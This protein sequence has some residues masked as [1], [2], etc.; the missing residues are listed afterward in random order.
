MNKE[1]IELG[2]EMLIS[3]TIIRDS[4]IEPYFI[5]KDATCYTV[6]ELTKANNDDTKPKRGRK[7]VVTEENKNKVYLKSHGYYTQF[8]NCLHKISE[9]KVNTTNYSSIKSYIDEW[10]RIREELNQ[11]INIGL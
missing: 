11:I 2:E 7:R 9:L 6:Y 8:E 10:K 1:V 3:S 4:K 5:G